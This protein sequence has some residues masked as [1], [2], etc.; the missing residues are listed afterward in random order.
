M[1][2]PGVAA[3]AT[4]LAIIASLASALF[5]SNRVRQ[6]S[7]FLTRLTLHFRNATLTHC[8]YLD[9]CDGTRIAS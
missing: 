7:E 8:I 3:R 5:L 1:H 6:L 2:Q 9:I 4:G